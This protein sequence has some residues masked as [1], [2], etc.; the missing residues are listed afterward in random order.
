MKN[1][2]IFPFFLFLNFIVVGQ[3]SIGE[4]SHS[5]Q[6]DNKTV[7][8]SFSV[9]N[10]MTN[11]IA[12]FISDRKHIYAYLTDDKFVVKKK[13]KFKKNT[14]YRGVVG[15]IYSPDNK[16]SF[17][18]SNVNVTTF[19]T[20]EFDFKK[21]TVVFTKDPFK[22]KGL[23]LLQN[24]NEQNKSHLV[25]LRK[26]TSELVVRTYTNNKKATNTT[27]NLKGDTFLIG[28]NKKTSLTKLLYNTL[29]NDY[30]I[31]KIQ[32]FEYGE[33]GNKIQ[34]VSIETTA[35]YTKLY[36]ENDVIKIV[37][38]KNK[39][40]TQ[41]LTLNLKKGTHSL[42]KIEKP[43]SEITGRNKASN[44]YIFNNFLFMTACSRKNLGVAVYDLEN[45]KK[46]KE[47]TLNYQQKLP[48]KDVPI[49]IQ[50]KEYK[51]VNKKQ[52]K[53]FFRKIY[54]SD[55]GITVAKQNN[56]FIVTIG[57]KKPA[58]LHNPMMS[59]KMGDN[60]SIY[61]VNNYRGFLDPHSYI[62]NTF[63]NKKST[64]FKGVLDNEFNFVSI[65]I[66]E[67]VYDTINSYVTK[68]RQQENSHVFEL[69]GKMI[70][71]YYDQSANMYK[72]LAF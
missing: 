56:N 66:K 4:F 29:Y 42:I 51:S 30:T 35:E 47:F 24:F 36:A 23:T 49:V 20:I 68:N 72:F 17:V 14:K 61:A 41:V 70:Y 40:Y 62:L 6:T 10:K 57:G 19:G 32:S 59:L 34:P 22:T 25:F 15:K 11:D 45:G 9:V 60:V 53:V 28:K 55:I 71:S 13:L 46:L 38:D 31:T 58:T 54:Y 44:S 1:A 27:F 2:F 7:K 39:Y 3:K 5:L 18:V 37:F 16:F 43:L 52:T 48:F 63:R 8:G 50:G 12:T 21:D 33:T 64:Y 26:K 69:N 67:N 65:P